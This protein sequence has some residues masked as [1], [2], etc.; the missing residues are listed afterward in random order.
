M[1]A[2]D[3]DQRTAL[4]VA[5]ADGNLPAVKVL[6]EGGGASLDVKDRWGLGLLPVGRAKSPPAW[7]ETGCKA[8]VLSRFTA[9]AEQAVRQL[10][11]CHAPLEGRDRGSDA[12]LLAAGGA[13]AYWTRP[14]AAARSRSSA[15]WRSATARRRR[16]QVQT[17]AGQAAV[18]VRP[19]ALPHAA[20]KLVY[21]RQALRQPARQPGS[22]QLVQPQ[23]QGS[24]A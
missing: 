18:A 20:A 14:G 12:W 17:A 15:T 24:A 2:G 5:A 21:G 16:R 6:V 13:Q 10:S 9:A 8:A 19:A 1:N 7:A 11:G 4:H 3:Y 23:I 22:Q